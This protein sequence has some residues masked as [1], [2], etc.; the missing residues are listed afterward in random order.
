MTSTS[1]L[2]IDRNDGLIPT[3]LQL[4]AEPIA[5]LTSQSWQLPSLPATVNYPALREVRDTALWK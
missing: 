3:V 5:S 1:S 4:A 2:V